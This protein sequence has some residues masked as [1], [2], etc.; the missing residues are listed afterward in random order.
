[1]PSFVANASFRAALYRY[2]RVKMF[3]SSSVKNDKKRKSQQSFLIKGEDIG[4]LV[5]VAKQNRRRSNNATGDSIQQMAFVIFFTALM[6]LLCGC[7]IDWNTP[8]PKNHE[9]KVSQPHSR[10][11]ARPFQIH[12]SPRNMFKIVMCSP[13]FQNQ[14]EEPELCSSSLDLAFQDF[15]CS[16]DPLGNLTVQYNTHRDDIDLKRSESLYLK[17]FHSI[18]R[19]WTSKDYV[20]H[21]SSSSPIPLSNEDH[22]QHQS[23]RRYLRF[24][25]GI[26]F[27]GRL[28]NTVSGMDVGF[29]VGWALASEQ[30]SDLQGIKRRKRLGLRR[31][32]KYIAGS[33]VKKRR[34]YFLNRLQSQTSTSTSHNTDSV[35]ITTGTS[36]G[37][38]DKWPSLNYYLMLIAK[39]VVVIRTTTNIL[40][41]C[42]LLYGVKSVIVLCWRQHRHLFIRMQRNR[43]DDIDQI[44]SR[45]MSDKRKA[46][47]SGPQHSEASKEIK[48]KKKKKK[49]TSRKSASAEP[50]DLLS[51]SI[52]H[53]VEGRP[54]NMKVSTDS[55][56][57]VSP[58][59]NIALDSTIVHLASIPF[60]NLSN[61]TTSRTTCEVN[62]RFNKNSDYGERVTSEMKCTD[63]SI[64]TS[65]ITSSFRSEVGDDSNHVS[66]TYSQRAPDEKR[67]SPVDQRISIEA[68]NC[69]SAVTNIGQILVQS[70]TAESRCS[71]TSP[72]RAPF[73]DHVKADSV[74]LKP[75]Q[76]STTS[77]RALAWSSNPQSGNSLATDISSDI[78]PTT[79]KATD[80]NYYLAKTPTMEQRE[81]A[82]KELKQFQSA[83]IDKLIQMK[84]EMQPSDNKEL[85]DYYGGVNKGI[86]NVCSISGDT[87]DTST[88]VA[89]TDES[90]MLS[91][92]YD[93]SYLLSGILDIDEDEDTNVGIQSMFIAPPLSSYHKI[94]REDD[95]KFVKAVNV[96]KEEET[97]PVSTLFQTDFSV[98]F[99]NPQKRNL[100]FSGSSIS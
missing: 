53:S 95:V 4:H 82:Y 47:I 6:I 73:I 18:A 97:N 40:M 64:R 93:F 58:Q 100:C 63:S 5:H 86:E 66:E 77:V 68:V 76:S 89:S 9:H 27:E 16:T 45:G 83:Q 67:R 41:C 31:A 74:E 98:I 70:K 60:S 14:E 59:Q 57:V 96:E 65:N 35:N 71:K 8:L 30:L 78:Q 80:Y 43:T 33:I 91:E 22:K 99:G 21:F 84:Q 23:S 1:M 13:G 2:G 3:A 28:S 72:K 36:V 7:C 69:S 38:E 37:L 49:T 44:S 61:Q 62:R 17:K 25:A 87:G 90:N 75:W 34:L 51:A 11:H 92:D 26:K 50:E 19:P 88:G 12:L 10:R 85:Y 46:V 15:R 79:K 24:G 48:K 20:T 42:C 29:E 81:E 39:W 52:F 94:T 56:S 54:F 55:F 32:K